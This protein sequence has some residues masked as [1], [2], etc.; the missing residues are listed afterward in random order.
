MLSMIVHR[1]CYTHISGLQYIY[2]MNKME[3]QK[4]QKGEEIAERCRSVFNHFTFLFKNVHR[5]ARCVRN[6]IVFVI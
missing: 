5:N 4:V 1:P 3:V 2:H 6:A